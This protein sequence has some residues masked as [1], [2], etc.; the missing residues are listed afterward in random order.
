MPTQWLIEQYA[1]PVQIR[2]EITVN[3]KLIETH[4]RA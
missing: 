3:W 1:I 2:R 4:C